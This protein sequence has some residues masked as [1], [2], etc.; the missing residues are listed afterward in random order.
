MLKNYFIFVDFIRNVP[1]FNRWM[2]LGV[3]VSRPKTLFAQ[4]WLAVTFFWR[5]QL[6]LFLQNKCWL[7]LNDTK[8]IKII[9]RLRLSY[10]FTIQAD[11]NRRRELAFFLFQTF[12]EA[13]E[14]RNFAISFSDCIIIFFSSFFGEIDEEQW[15]QFW[16]LGKCVWINW[17]AQLDVYAGLCKTL[18]SQLELSL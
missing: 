17:R 1:T 7:E 14:L 16:W 4:R 13:S 5:S 6:C 9:N 3:A 12:K 2:Q 18:S 10:E 15:R 8:C 11:H